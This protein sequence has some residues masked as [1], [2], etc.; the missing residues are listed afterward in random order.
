MAKRP[1]PKAGSGTRPGQPR[2]LPPPTL[3]AKVSVKKDK[4]FLDYF[5][6]IES[7]AAP[8]VN[9]SSLSS[10]GSQK[11]VEDE[12]ETDSLSSYVMVSAPSAQKTAVSGVNADVE[13]EKAGGAIPRQADLLNQAHASSQNASLEDGSRNPGP[14]TQHPTLRSVAVDGDVRVSGAP[15]PPASQGQPHESKGPATAAHSGNLAEVLS[16]FGTGH[17]P[18]E[19][20]NTTPSRGAVVRRKGDPWGFDEDDGGEDGE[21]FARLEKPTAATTIITPHLH[22]RLGTQSP[23]VARVSPH[24]ELFNSD[25]P[26]FDLVLEKSRSIPSPVTGHRVPER[27]LSPATSRHQQDNKNDLRTKSASGWSGQQRNLAG[28]MED[29]F[30]YITQ[31][32]KSAPSSGTEGRP[33]ADKLGG[34]SKQHRSDTAVSLHALLDDVVDDLEVSQKGMA[35]SPATGRPSRERS[36]SPVRPHQGGTRDVGEVGESSTQAHHAD[37]M[38][39]D[40]AGSGHSVRSKGDALP[41]AARC[42]GDASNPQ[43][44]GGGDSTS[45]DTNHHPSTADDASNCD[46]L[47][48]Q[49]MKAAVTQGTS[50]PELCEGLE[51]AELARSMTAST[52]GIHVPVLVNEPPRS[53][54]H[55][56]AQPSEL[57]SKAP[58]PTKQLDSRFEVLQVSSDPSP[59]QHSLSSIT[60]PPQLV[61]RSMGLPSNLSLPSTWVPDSVEPVMFQLGPEESSSEAAIS[62]TEQQQSVP[63]GGGNEMADP[64]DPLSEGI[65][66]RHQTA[67]KCNWMESVKPLA[68]AHVMES[69]KPLA[70]AHGSSSEQSHS[71]QESPPKQTNQGAPIQGPSESVSSKAEP[72]QVTKPV[73]ESSEGPRSGEVNAHAQLEP[74]SDTQLRHPLEIASETLVPCN[75]PSSEKR[76][77]ELPGEVRNTLEQLSQSEASCTETQHIELSTGVRGA[78]PHPFIPDPTPSPGIP[79]TSEAPSHQDLS[80]TMSGGSPSPSKQDTSP[81]PV[82]ESSPPN[83][84]DGHT[85]KKPSRPVLSHQMSKILQER[86]GSSLDMAAS[87]APQ[88]STKDESGQA[89]PSSERPAAKATSTTPAIIPTAPRERSSF[90]SLSAH[91]RSKSPGSKSTGNHGNS[92]MLPTVTQPTTTSVR[93]PSTSQP[94]PALQP[95]APPHTVPSDLPTSSS[96]SNLPTSS[97]LPLSALPSFVSPNFTAVAV[98]PLHTLPAYIQPVPTSTIQHPISTSTTNNTIAQ[99]HPTTAQPPDSHSSTLSLTFQ[100]TTVPIILHP[101]E[102]TTKGQEDVVLDDPLTTEWNGGMLAPRPSDGARLGSGRDAPSARPPTPSKVS[103]PESEMLKAEKP[104]P[105][106]PPPS[107]TSSSSETAP[108]PAASVVAVQDSG[109]AAVAFLTEASAHPMLLFEAP[110]QLHLAATLML[111]VY[112]SLNPWNYLA[113]LLAGFFIF[114]FALLSAFIVVVYHTEEALRKELSQQGAQ[115]VRH[116]AFEDTK[117]RIQY[118]E[119]KE[120]LLTTA[121][122]YETFKAVGEKLKS[123]VKLQNNFTLFVKAYNLVNNQPQT[124]FV[125]RTDLRHCDVCLV[126]SHVAEKRRRR[127]SKKYPIRVTVLRGQHKELFLFCATSRMKEEWFRRLRDAREGRSAEF[128]IEQRQRFFHYIHRYFPSSTT[129]SVE[130]GTSSYT[131]DPHASQEMVPSGMYGKGKSGGEGLRRP[132]PSAA[133][134][135]VNA[136]GVNATV[137]R[138]DDQ[139]ASNLQGKVEMVSMTTASAI[140]A[141]EDDILDTTPLS[142]KVTVPVAKETDWMNVFIARL[143]WDVWHEDFW[144]KWA[145]AKI[146]NVLSRVTTPSFMEKLKVSDVKL[147]MDTPV[148]NKLVEG[149]ILDPEGTW[150]YLDITYTGSFTMTIETKL[151]GHRSNP[152]SDGSDGEEEE[153]QQQVPPQPGPATPAEYQRKRTRLLGMVSKVAKIAYNNSSLVRKAAERVSSFPLVLTV[154]VRRL[155]GVLAINIPPPPSD[156]IWVGFRE[157]PKLD[158]VATPQVGQKAVTMTPGDPLD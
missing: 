137:A 121:Y 47:L 99:P 109:Q 18:G 150:V 79:P 53:N 108:T 52:S 64:G 62:L 143:C 14:R 7:S 2:V 5:D 96:S 49:V 92:A 13:L 153:E 29:D 30:E 120:F 144:K 131:Y 37:Q 81:S 127:W 141:S 48:P 72:A 86:R 105:Q 157:S 107:S 27:G 73:E 156:T 101:L 139:H 104:R 84:P 147:G 95:W 61:V 42:L 56:H 110:L 16:L 154:V 4:D 126:P 38:G 12:P 106:P 17:D 123:E 20:F 59:L 119:S 8:R 151:K 112:Y 70:E 9:A 21:E 136:T 129:A 34:C 63:P 158:L 11:R 93:P 3:D 65:E 44:V 68:E 116:K 25:D 140:P 149:P 118:F 88:P 15:Q 103:E 133:T 40:D 66:R 75:D 41:A 155:D 142:S 82:P 74:S 89:L 46:K 78:H 146:Q 111:Y 54:G 80:G 122:N 35:V 83:P 31:V 57:P 97:S 145:T 117:L 77:L 24:T 113:G 130:R 19:I 51:T 58:E 39:G 124:L 87:P 23:R 43:R 10:N 32:P 1:T 67:Q 100:P 148:I 71:L 60:S 76:Q 102:G 55:T 128:L 45:H 132:L 115:P 36:L 22:S 50:Q 69:V 85:P 28:P 152:D 94:T 134:T 33:F 26:E 98:Q 91:F 138:R 6:D 114:Y 125:E 90:K 135:G